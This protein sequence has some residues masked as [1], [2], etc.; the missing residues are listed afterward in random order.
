M[1]C[2]NFTCIHFCKSPDVFDHCLAAA[3]LMIVDLNVHIIRGPLV[4]PHTERY[5]QRLGLMVA[6]L[7]FAAG[8]CF[9][10]VSRPHVP[11]SA[12]GSAKI[13]CARLPCAIPA[14][15]HANS[16]QNPCRAPTGNPGGPHGILH[17]IAPRPQSRVQNATASST[18]HKH[19]RN[20][21]RC[22]GFGKNSEFFLGMCPAGCSF[23]L[24]AQLVN[25]KLSLPHP[26]D[27]REISSAACMVVRLLESYLSGKIRGKQ[28]RGDGFC[29]KSSGMRRKVLKFLHGAP[30][31]KK[32]HKGPSHE[33]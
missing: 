2:C 15:A 3:N 9:V 32:C 21:F 28:R 5:L 24:L 4:R 30:M 12:R 33:K 20:R 13:M 31:R 22:N 23:T 14:E 1:S 25:A 29:I 26:L 18:T 6:L 16:W 19:G 17:H 8:C 7:F 11:P 10:V 27:G